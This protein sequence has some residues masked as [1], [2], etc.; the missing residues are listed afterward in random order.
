MLKTDVVHDR[1][2][3]WV[4]LNG[5]T[6][7]APMPI[8]II[9]GRVDLAS[10]RFAGKARLSPLNNN[11][12]VAHE[13]RPLGPAAFGLWAIFSLFVFTAGFVRCS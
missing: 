8:G 3:C 5:K 10:P 13:I 6:L 12:W 4:T 2:E 1:R 11:R 9:D 7:L